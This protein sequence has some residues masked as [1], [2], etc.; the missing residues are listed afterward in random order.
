[1]EKA[2]SS[3]DGGCQWSAAAASQ[4]AAPYRV[5]VRL[6]PPDTQNWRNEAIGHV[7]EECERTHGEGISL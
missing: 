4:Q 3:S 5:Q 7:D 2:D 1:M 6:S